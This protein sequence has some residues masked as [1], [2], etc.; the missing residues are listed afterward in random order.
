MDHD[1]ELIIPDPGNIWKFD[2]YNFLI[3]WK[4][5]KSHFVHL[6]SPQLPRKH[7]IDRW[8][9]HL[10]LQVRQAVG[11]CGWHEEATASCRD[12]EFF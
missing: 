10:S 12:Y 11:G 6:W 5:W 4:Y 2:F 9:F 8:N 7:D 1:L 3:S